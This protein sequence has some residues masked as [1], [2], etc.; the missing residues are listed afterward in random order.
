MGAETK[1]NN[2]MMIAKV[3]KS[4]DLNKIF[5]NAQALKGTDYSISRQCPPEVEERRQFAWSAYK[6]AR[7][8]NQ[9]ARF[10]PMGRLI[11]NDVVQTKFEPVI[12]PSTSDA[13]VVRGAKPRMPMIGHSEEYVESHHEFRAWASVV[14]DLQEIRDS[15]DFLMQS[16]SFSDASH[17]PYAYRYRNT[18]GKIVENFLSDGDHFAG[19]QILKILQ[20]KDIE[21]VAVFINHRISPDYLTSKKKIEILSKVIISALSSLDSFKE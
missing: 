17:V 3:P 6:D 4:E 5:N 1:N 14:T 20:S 10:D 13:L 16:G 18:A 11:I 9:S 8:K 7:K 12:L 2:K 21:N 15:T 19:L